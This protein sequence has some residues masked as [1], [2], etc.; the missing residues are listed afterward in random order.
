DPFDN[1]EALKLSPEA[2][3]SAMARQPEQVHRGK[4]R[5]AGDFYLLPVAWAERAILAVRSRQQVL[6]AFR[7]YRRWLMRASTD[8]TIPLSNAALAGPGFSR[9]AKRRTL[10]KLEA[11]RLIEVVERGKGQA[12]RVRILG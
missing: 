4:T 10:Q 11:A 8:G 12:P 2:V 7:L 3:A 1:L 6:L 5:L 9:K